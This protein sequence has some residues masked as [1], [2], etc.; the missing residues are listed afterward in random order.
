[1]NRS[2]RSARLRTH[3]RCTCR[4]CG[5]LPARNRKRLA[6]KRVRQAARR[7]IREAPREE[8]LEP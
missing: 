8:P 5:D 1:M 3:G 7:A 4:L 6:S 2:D